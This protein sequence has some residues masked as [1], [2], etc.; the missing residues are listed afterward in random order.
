MNLYGMDIKIGPISDDASF[1]K[2][3]IEQW[4]K[5]HRDYSE[6]SPG[7]NR[8]LFNERANLSAFAGA[9]WRCGGYV[10]E[11][12]SARKGDKKSVGRIDLYFLYNGKE[13]ICEAKHGWLL[14]SGQKNKGSYIK[15]ILYH[16]LLASRDLQE[17]LK[18][19]TES[20]GLSLTF[21]TSYWNEKNEELKE[22]EKRHAGEIVGQIKAELE[23]LEEPEKIANL[24]EFKELKKLKKMKN[25]EEFEA[26]TGKNLFYAYI[27]VKDKKFKPLILVGQYHGKPEPG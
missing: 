16:H 10:V 23:E 15:D 11:E 17:T 26:F 3:I 27:D 4:V 20:H 1:L 25:I 9:I 13:V 12:Y 21:I 18:A 5:L 24:K 22:G 2:P 19:N 7:R 6:V 8:Y 14:L